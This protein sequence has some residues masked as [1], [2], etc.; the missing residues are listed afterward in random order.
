MVMIRAWAGAVAHAGGDMQAFL[1]DAGIA[2]HLIEDPSA[3]IE[4]AIYDRVQELAVERTGDPALG[5]HVGERLAA[6]TFGAA[7]HLA[8]QCATL[9][10]AAE[11][12]SSYFSLLSDST[13]P[14]IEQRGTQAFMRHEF[15]RAGPVVNRLRPE[16]ALAAFFAFGR[17]FVG[18]SDV[19]PDEVWFE[20][21]RPPYGDEYK[22]V[23]G[24]EPR[25]RQDKSGILFSDALLDSARLDADPL[26]FRLLRTEAER[27]LAAVR[28][29]SLA[30]R[31]YDIVSCADNPKHLDMREVATRLQMSERS[32][33]R[34]LAEEKRSFRDVV[35]DA[36]HERVLRLLRDPTLTIEDVAV[37][38]GF[39]ETSTFHRAVR[40]WTSRTVSEVRRVLIGS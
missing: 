11:M 7:G 17:M 25:F 35:D 22:R 1:R 4:L 38:A 18:R 37:R 10:A 6:Y 9:R 14:T 5:L 27:M 26:V 31:V 39:A 21:E 28:G 2:P 33:R 13:P 24:I 36:L 12:L 3:R 20:H 16:F 15:P 19:V 23:F 30:S 40:R 8:S 29:G 32:L 34:K